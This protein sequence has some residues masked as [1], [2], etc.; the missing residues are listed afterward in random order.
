MERAMLQEFLGEG[1][2]LAEIGRW[3]GRHEATVAYWVAKHGLVPA[4]RDAHAAKGA[5]EHEVLERLVE[6][7]LSIEQRA[8][9]VERSRTTVRHWLRRYGLETQWAIRRRASRSG[10]ALLT[11][12]CRHHGVVEFAL[13]AGGGYRCVRC[14]ADA[15]SRRRRRVKRLLV[16]E[17][18]GRC[19]RCGYDRCLGALAFHHVVPAEKSFS[20]SH[21]GVSRS[22]AR[23][24]DEAAKCVLLCANCH[25]EVEAEGRM[26]Q[27]AQTGAL[28]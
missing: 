23:A 2:S 4:R 3:V 8:A 14:T 27:E 21:R 16:Q 19:S 6:Q 1:L 28:E 26:L 20:L 10:E 17:A 18:G 9:R 12:H 5:L 11:L 24:R 25:S 13:R 7:G 22:I 15:V